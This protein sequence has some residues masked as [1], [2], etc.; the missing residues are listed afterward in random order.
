VIHDEEM[1]SRSNILLARLNLWL[2]GFR[3]IRIDT[4]MRYNA[5]LVTG[6]QNAAIVWTIYQAMSIR[7]IQEIFRL[8]IYRWE[9]S[10]DHL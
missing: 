4:G 3:I 9:E 10:C 2:L 6:I 8:D 1:V 5:Y 7:I